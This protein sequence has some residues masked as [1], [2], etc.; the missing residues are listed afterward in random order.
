LCK[1]QAGKR[2]RDICCSAVPSLPVLH[3]CS[4]Y[5]EINLHRQSIFFNSIKHRTRGCSVD[6][7]MGYALLWKPAY[8][9][10]RRPIT[11]C[12]TY[13]ICSPAAPP[14]K[15][16]NPVTRKLGL[17]LRS[18]TLPFQP[19]LIPDGRAEQRCGDYWL[20]AV[21]WFETSRLHRFIICCH[22]RREILLCGSI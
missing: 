14:R 6:G 19:D 3:T 1:A 22:W 15:P 12:V 8:S 10:I 9:H 13:D 7:T 17:P 20:G 18:P 4:I 2:E 16:C 21:G 11:I 5:S